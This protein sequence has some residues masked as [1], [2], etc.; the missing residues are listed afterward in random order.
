[1]NT[2][3]KFMKITCM[4]L[5]VAMAVGLC[6]GSV[7]AEEIGG[8]PA[9]GSANS[10]NADTLHVVFTN[11]IHGYAGDE[12]GADG[13]LT[14]AGYARVK[15]YY[16]SVVNQYGESNTLL[17]DAG[18][19][20]QGNSF[21]AIDEGEGVARLMGQMNYS[22][23]VPGNH[24]FDYGLARLNELY[25]QVNAPVLAV[26]VRD[27]DGKLVYEPYMTFDK[28]GMKVGV[29]G[30]ASQSSAEDAASHPDARDLDF[31]TNESVIQD[32]Q[33][34]VNALKQEGCDVI[35]ALAHL[36][37]ES[38]YGYVTS[39]DI[40]DQVSGVDVIMD[41]HIH[42]TYSYIRNGV[43]I[44]SAGSYSRNYG[45]IDISKNADGTKNIVVQIHD[46]NTL[47]NVEPNAQVQ[48]TYEEICREHDR[49]LNQ[50]IGHTPYELVGKGTRQQE[51]NFSRLVA[52]DVL[53][54]CGDQAE[55]AFI[56]GGMIRDSIPAG[57]V[58]MGD[59]LDAIP[60]DNNIVILEMT[61]QDIIDQ[62]EEV[63][64]DGTD[65]PVVTGMIINAVQQAGSENNAANQLLSV[66]VGGSP[67]DPAKTYRV[68]TVDYLASGG[69]AHSVMTH[70]KQVA[71]I[72]SMRDSLVDYFGYADFEEI[73]AADPCLCFRT[74]Q[75]ANVHIKKDDVAWSDN[76]FESVA[77]ESNNGY[78][79]DL[80]MNGAEATG[81]PVNDTYSILVDGKDTTQTIT[82]TETAPAEA[83]LNYYTVTFN[84][85]GADD[86]A[87]PES[88]A[89]AKGTQMQLPGAGS[90]AKQGYSFEGWNTKADGS[91]EG[92]QPGDFC[93][94]EGTTD[95]YAKWAVQENASG[96]TENA[97]G[98]T[99]NASTPQT[100]DIN[101]SV[102]A[103][104]VVLAGATIAL[105]RKR[106]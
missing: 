3:S 60:F 14:K 85:N 100:G 61:G 73:N 82:V 48:T 66:T 58:T 84:S 54:A 92:Y 5:S 88:V 49:I 20:F 71:S 74:Y 80:S 104:V 31:G 30:I 93:V 97:S 91:G 53:H 72:G 51:T 44:C 70:C 86:G 41:G 12:F 55:I 21:A 95:F 9:Q 35:L 59:L 56:H 32:S 76:G 69:S 37:N 101:V 29:F 105:Q 87:S 15:G 63:F 24:E 77:L 42:Q 8:D 75:T 17:F 23:I 7:L 34:A 81:T 19:Y 98:G 10:S 26:N 96:G 27:K 25:D 62:V 68:A 50:V 46:A 36:G 47:K 90:M 16:D 38:G 99:A 94:V 64:A 89:Y 57:D 2:K 18:D 6:T 1:M 52:R 65:V 79:F 11:D 39:N 28:A 40:A 106:D 83:D 4:I 103:A 13:N 43:Q 45:T 67:I 102:L 22:A 78:R 33:N